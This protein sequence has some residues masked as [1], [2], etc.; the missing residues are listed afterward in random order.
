MIDTQD[1]QDKIGALQCL[2]LNILLNAILQILL[3]L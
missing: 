3:L 1:V 2:I